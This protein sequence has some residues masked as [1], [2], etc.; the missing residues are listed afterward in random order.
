MIGTIISGCAI[1]G[2]IYSCK[3]LGKLFIKDES[4][5][6]SETLAKEIWEDI[7]CRNGI[8][9]QI[10][11][12]SILTPSLV[13]VEEINNGLRY[14]FKI[15]LGITSE[16]LQVCKLQVK[17][18]SNAMD[19]DISHYKGD[20]VHID[21]IT[22]SDIEVFEGSIDN[23]KWNKLWIELDLTSKISSF[24]YT[25]PTLISES[26]IIGGTS[27]IFQMP[28]GK[29][30]HHVLKHDVTI[31][32]FLEAKQIEILPI[33]K[34]RV[35]IKSFDEE[36]PELVPFEL[37]P[38][39]SKDSFEVPIG[40]FIDGYAVL[41]FKKVANVLDAGM[42]GSGKSVATKS[43]LTYLGC[44]YS[45]DELNIYISDL[46]MT[47]LNRFK[48]MKHVVKYTDTKKGTG[49]MIKELRNIMNER[50]AKFKKLK[51]SDIYEY[52][53]K[54]PESK[55]PYIFLAID[56]ISRY[57]Q[58]IS[59]KPYNRFSEG[60]DEN[61]ILSELLFLARASGISVWCS[62]QRPTKEN[63]NP[64]VKSSLGNILAFKTA[65]ANNSR[66]IC[67]NEE[68]LQ[69]LRGRGNGYLITEGIDK[70]FQGF[71]IENDEIERILTDRDLLKEEDD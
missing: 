53:K 5:T 8:F 61:Q 18:L 44:M 23:N 7:W 58:S 40:K 22:K 46:K 33:N 48:N 49:D 16:D 3:E 47:E 25:Y 24:G 32:E 38:R 19:I 11:E 41:D 20:I 69:Y 6:N 51:V 21:V 31:K 62:V 35:E 64:D 42:Q 9:I 39:S 67:D 29:S 56:E 52:N 12:E 70:E 14:V 4:V 68:K 27:Y 10:D 30:S 26:N 63:L 45:P 50:Y 55:M 36:L 37:Y 54:Y 15:P 65:D 59:S 60:E 28:V 13:S 43:A 71:Y 34:N 66:I 1:G 2:L 57:T 17:E